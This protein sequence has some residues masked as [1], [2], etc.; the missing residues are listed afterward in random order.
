MQCCHPS[1]MEKTQKSGTYHLSK[2]IASVLALSYSY[3]EFYE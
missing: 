1:F 2:A 3:F